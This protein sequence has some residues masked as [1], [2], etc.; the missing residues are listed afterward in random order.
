MPKEKKRGD[1]VASSRVEKK[2]IVKKGEQHQQEFMRRIKK[3]IGG[4]NITITCEGEAN[5]FSDFAKFLEDK[6]NK[7]KLN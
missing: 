2:N 3:A 1:T 7:K 5:A 6:I 4:Q